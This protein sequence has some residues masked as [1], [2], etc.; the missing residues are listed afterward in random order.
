MKDYKGMTLEQ[1]KAR[2]KE[3]KKWQNETGKLWDSDAKPGSEPKVEPFELEN[4]Q[5]QFN[6]TNSQINEIVGRDSIGQERR[7]G[8][9]H[10]MQELM[11]KEHLTEEEVQKLTTAEINKRLSND[12][13]FSEGQKLR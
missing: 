13:G 3:I 10:K 9:W 2:I 5:K 11:K 1:V 8:D 7:L 4:I 6:L 12:G